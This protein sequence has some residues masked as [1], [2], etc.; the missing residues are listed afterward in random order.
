MGYCLYITKADHPVRSKV[1]PITVAELRQA[2]SKD[3]DL[4][5]DGRSRTR[6]VWYDDLGDERGRMLLH[7]G[8][9]VAKNPSQEFIAKMTALARFL[10]AQV[11]GDDGEVYL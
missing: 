7:H 3:P 4:G 11:V 5:F 9:V 2:V 6:V 8:R 1:V 10:G